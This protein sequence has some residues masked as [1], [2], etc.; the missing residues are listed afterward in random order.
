MLAGDPNQTKEG[1]AFLKRSFASGF[2]DGEGAYYLA[3]MYAR[4]GLDDEAI[5]AVEQAVELG[6]L[7]APSFRKNPGLDRIRGHARFVAAMEEAERGHLA[8]VEIFSRYDGETLL[9]VSE[10]GPPATPRKD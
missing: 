1:L 10:V 5:E 4:V 9:G 8:A 7:C 2:R 6:Y 3:Q